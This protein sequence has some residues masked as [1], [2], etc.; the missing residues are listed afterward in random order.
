MTDWKFRGHTKPVTV[1]EDTGH[2]W[3]PIISIATDGV[4][5]CHNSSGIVHMTRDG[6]VSYQ[7]GIVEYDLLQV[8][9]CEEL[10]SG[11]LVMVWNTMGGQPD[12]VLRR[13]REI[14][15]K[16]QV[17]VYPIPVD[18]QKNIYSYALPLDIWKEEV[19]L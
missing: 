14:T 5:R 7:A 15:A 18:S 11:D 8:H 1:I 10:N 12:A 2:K 17:W 4:L 19:C 13:F 9:P 6:G 3:C 16:S